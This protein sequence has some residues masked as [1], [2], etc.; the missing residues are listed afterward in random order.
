MTKSY[1]ELEEF[2]Y[3]ANK[4]VI[5]HKEAQKTDNIRVFI[6]DELS[7]EALLQVKR[8]IKYL[9]LCL[10]HF[11]T[12]EDVIINKKLINPNDEKG[13][14]Y[15]KKIGFQSLERAFLSSLSDFD[16]SIEQFSNRYEKYT[17]YLSTY[18]YRQFERSFME[19]FAAQI[20]GAFQDNPN[21]LKLDLAELMQTAQWV[22]R[23][24]GEMTRSNLRIQN[25]II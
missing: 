3:L 8:E 10:L 11:F 21:P 25:F 23:T 14:Y 20:T 22:F 24:Y 2:L 15:F 1:I 6:R 16:Y 7:A 17:H 19:C 9:M 4:M 12:F 5:N 18:N 13:L